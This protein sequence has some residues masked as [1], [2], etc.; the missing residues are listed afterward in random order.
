MEGWIKGIPKS[1][2]GDISVGILDSPS[3]ARA[4]FVIPDETQGREQVNGFG[5]SSIKHEL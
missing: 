4:P 5:A 2:Q 3:F 1:I